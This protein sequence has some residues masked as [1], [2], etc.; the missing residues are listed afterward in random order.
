MIS[1]PGL[2][3]PVIGFL[4]CKRRIGKK[5][6]LSWNVFALLLVLCIFVIGMLSSESPVQRFGFEQP[7]IAINYFPFILLPA[8]IVP[9]VIYTHI[10]DILK[11]RKD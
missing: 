7:N 5:V 1:W 11:L 6:L 8:T 9:I 3:A 4:W 10:T 2:S